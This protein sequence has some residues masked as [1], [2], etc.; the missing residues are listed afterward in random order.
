MCDVDPD[1]ILFQSLV[2]TSD[3]NRATSA[4][5]SGDCCAPL[6]QIIGY[7]PGGFACH[8]IVAVVMEINESWRNDHAVTVDSILDFSILE[9]ANSHNS[10][11]ANCNVANNGRLP[12]PHVDCPADQ[13]KISIDRILGRC[14]NNQTDSKENEIQNGTAQKSQVF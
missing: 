13:N 9:F 10:I 1:T 14:G 4:V 11:V 7:S 2:E 12:I 5:A 3:I 6:S 8:R